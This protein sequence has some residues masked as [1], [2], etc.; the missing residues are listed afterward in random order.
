MAPVELPR[1]AVRDHVVRLRREVLFVA[2]E[3]VELSH[4]QANVGESRHAVR[5]GGGARIVPVLEHR[6]SRLLLRRDSGLGSGVGGGYVVV[7][8]REC[9]DE[10]RREGHRDNT[11]ELH[12]DEIRWRNDVCRSESGFDGLV[13]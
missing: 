5:D 1:S 7:G 8:V 12:V 4:D 13:E 10:E 6:E 2:P 9:E 11:K 3:T